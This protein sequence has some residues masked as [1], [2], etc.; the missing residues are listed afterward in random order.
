MEISS[1]STRT[2]VLRESW[3]SK[4]R[5]CPL[6][7]AG[8]LAAPTFRPANESQPPNSS[9][10]GAWRS[11]AVASEGRADT[12][13]RPSSV[14]LKVVVPSVESRRMASY[15]RWGSVQAERDWAPT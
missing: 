2:P 14:S 12:S 13:E 3:A 15:T 11:S 7:A 6:N 4:P 5:I 10:V 8:H 1:G 9:T